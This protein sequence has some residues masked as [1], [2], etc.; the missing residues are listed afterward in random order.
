M[1][2]WWLAKLVR[3]SVTSSTAGSATED[4]DNIRLRLEDVP[5]ASAA[6]RR[7]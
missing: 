7:S 5:R 6:A 1:D 2:P 4:V 3:F